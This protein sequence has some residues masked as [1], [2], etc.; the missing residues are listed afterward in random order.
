MG[1]DPRT[2]SQQRMR[3]VGSDHR[4]VTAT[5]K[6]S[7]RVSKNTAS[8]KLFWSAVT[9]NKQLAS[10][11]EDTVK[12]RYENLPL[13]E[14]N[15]TSFVNIAHKTGK[16]LL[17]RKPRRAQDTRDADPVVTARKATLRASTRNVQAAQVNLRKTYDRCEDRRTNETLTYGIPLDV[18]SAIRVM[19]EDTSA[20][21]ITP[22]GETDAFSINTGVLQ[23][24]PLAPFL[25]CYLPRLCA[26]VFDFRIRRAY[27][28]SSSEPTIP[29]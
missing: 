20:V 16:E 7:L 14:Q 10:K 22:E 5:V 3:E 17:P 11:I 4:I 12:S 6:L 18:V 1:L 19:Y 26:P 27:S 28:P 21:V 23:G 29:S 15:Y 13:S 2:G 9:K 8:K 25:F 24:D